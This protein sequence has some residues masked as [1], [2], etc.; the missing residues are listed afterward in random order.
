M[1][2]TVVLTGATGRI[3][4]HIAKVLTKRGHNLALLCRDVQ[5]GEEL[6]RNLLR[7]NSQSRI[8]V[9][10][11]DLCSL[12]SVRSV[13]EELEC[14]YRRVD[15][16]VNAAG[17]VEPPIER[18]LT[19]DGIE[20]TFHTNALAPFQLMVLL[21]PLLRASGSGRIVNVAASTGLP[22]VCRTDMQGANGGAQSHRKRQSS[23][24]NPEAFSAEPSLRR[25]FLLRKSYNEKNAL[26]LL[27]SDEQRM[28]RQQQQ[29]QHA[30]QGLFEDVTEDFVMAQFKRALA[31]CASD[32][33]SA[34]NWERA[35][36]LLNEME[37][38]GLGPDEEDYSMAIRICERAGE[39]DAARMLLD[40]LEA[41]G[42]RWK[43]DGSGSSDG[44]GSSR[45]TLETLDH[46]QEE[47]Q[48][49]ANAPF[50]PRDVAVPFQ[51]YASPDSNIGVFSMYP[52]VTGAFDAYGLATGVGYSPSDAYLQSK[53]A[54]RQLSW[55]AAD[56]YR[57]DEDRER[58]SRRKYSHS[59]GHRQ[60]QTCPP[61]TRQVHRYQILELG[62]GGQSWFFDQEEEGIGELLGSNSTSNGGGHGHQKNVYSSVLDGSDAHNE[63][64]GSSYDEKGPSVRVHVCH[65][66]EVDSP[67]LDNFGL[68][69]GLSTAAQ[70]AEVPAFLASD[71]RIDRMGH[72]PHY[73]NPKLRVQP[74]EYMAQPEQYEQ[75]WRMCVGMSR[76]T[77]DSLAGSFVR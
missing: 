6:A 50:E 77:V 56:R 18:E 63:Q 55:A 8:K 73:W 13:V 29:Q 66:G 37:E 5:R 28:I 69:R 57:R 22:H 60:Y 27:G 46:D 3:G 31:Q 58:A 75:L 12:D 74:C 76:I 51:D 59:K 16:L 9:H 43:D 26:G 24:A 11:V 45:E 1:N 52:L 20:K 68:S 41:V 15:V 44:W 36:H 65:P 10:E 42:G 14:S 72:G 23:R 21:R 40:E 54:L 47:R 32:T 19:V 17:L 38:V 67:L 7:N 70:A 4:R 49:Q 71:V 34:P 53:I 2:R 48:Q 30:M 33:R 62:N 25:D 35:V 64:D 61:Q 39:W